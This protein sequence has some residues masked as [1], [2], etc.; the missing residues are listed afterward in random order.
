MQVELLP[1]QRTVEHAWLARW[2]TILFSIW[3]QWIKNINILKLSLV[4]AHLLMHPEGSGTFK[5]AAELVQQSHKTVEIM[6]KILWK[7]QKGREQH[8]FSSSSYPLFH[9]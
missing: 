9:P 1:A 2:E 4:I 7:Q 3:F 8:S 6:Q 5:G